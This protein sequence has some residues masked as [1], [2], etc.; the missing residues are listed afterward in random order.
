MHRRIIYYV[1]TSL[2]GYIAGPGGDISGFVGAGDGVDRYLADL[3]AFDT[4]IMGRNT[5]TFGYRFGL[6]PGQPAYGH[7]T[8]YIFSD[9]LVL[10]DRDPKVNVMHVDLRNIQDIRRQPGSDIY[11]CGGG[12]FAGWLLD[13]G[14][15]DV[16]KIKLNPLVLGGGTRLFGDSTTTLNLRLTDSERFD[17]GLQIITFAITPPTK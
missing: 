6:K 4:V 2:D 8:H 13:H 17:D 10:P 15:I 7:M 3:A 12:R 11:L 5:Y 9:N 1:A 14:M 16:L